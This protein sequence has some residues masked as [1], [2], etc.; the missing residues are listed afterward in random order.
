[1]KISICNKLILSLETIFISLFLNQLNQG[2]KTV[3]GLTL[4]KN[5]DYSSLARQEYYTEEDKSPTIAEES[6]EEV[7][8]VKIEILSWLS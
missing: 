8:I 1:M 4:R 2:E 7:K 6:E 5:N 3:H